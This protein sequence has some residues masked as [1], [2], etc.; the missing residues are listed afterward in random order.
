MARF[1]P[2]EGEELVSVTSCTE[3][4][5]KY[6]LL[7]FFAKHG[8]EAGERIGKEAAALGT[9]L[10]TYAQEHYETMLKGTLEEYTQHN[11]CEKL[12]QSVKNFHEFVDEYSP[13][14]ILLEQTVYSL[15]HKYAGTLDG[16]FKIGD[17]IVLL[18]WKTSAGVYDEYLLQLEAYYRALTEMQKRG[19]IVL[20]GKVKD[21]WV[22]RLAKDKDI[23]FERDVKIIKPSK[24]R[25][26]AFLGLVDIFYWRQ[27]LKK[28]KRK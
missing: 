1:Y 6:G 16:I 11:F 4:L 3:Q 8:K 22:V 5:G 19:I 27:S 26:K 14:P 9:S 15:E 2:A 25:F 20:D 10:H 12:E 23:K 24:K 18:D 28:R 21:L 7:M 13:E 17:N